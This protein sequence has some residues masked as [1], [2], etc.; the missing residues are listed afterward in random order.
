MIRQA[1]PKRSYD[2]E[3]LHRRFSAGE[4]THQVRQSLGWTMAQHWG[5][6]VLQLGTTMVL[7]RL[8]TP[9]DY[10]L[11]GMALTV[12]VIV[13]QLRSMGLSSAVVQRRDLTMNQV[14][15]LFYANALA[16]LV[17]A[18]LVA[19]LAP[20]VAAFY[21]RPELVPITLAL[22]ATYALS[23]FGV[24]ASALL[25]RRLDFRKLAVRQ[26][27]ARLLSSLIAVAAAAVGAGYWALVSQQLAF[28][29]FMLVLVWV[30]VPWR[31]GRP[32]DVRAAV[33]LVKFGAGVSL[34]GLFSAFGGMAD[35]III[36]RALG[37]ADLGLYSRAHALQKMPLG[38]L[39]Q[40]LNGAM[41]P[42][43]SAVQEEPSRYRRLYTGAI[44]GLGMVALPLAIL[45]AVTATDT[46][47]VFLGEQ[48]VDAAPVFR[49]LALAGFSLVI[50]SSV[51]WLYTSVG[52]GK[53]FAQ[54]SAVAAAVRIVACFIG[55]RWGVVGVAAALATT[56]T[57]LAPAA[58][59]FGSRGTPV[60]VRDIATSLVRP[61]V[62]SIAVLVSSLGVLS[63]VASGMAPLITLVV[64]SSAAVCTWLL[65]VGSWPSAR[66][67][68]KGLLAVMRPASR[69]AKRS[70][71]DEPR[72]RDGQK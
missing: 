28:S 48:W 70:A 54:W 42:L 60:G 72:M 49:W 43:L 3:H 6:F 29:L 68:V 64:V 69:G 62:I 12:T 26:T 27:A 9:E 47:L 55:I 50:T 16:G 65:V 18:A 4:F 46:I 56:Q 7:A 11:V 15:T 41:T 37:A 17:L 34:A 5:S 25:T 24:Q 66:S 38:Q 71:T 52:R 33:P 61:F 8:L 58:L 36:G 30:A 44:G 23:G 21:G 10:G 59:Y 13:D 53:A 2:E 31:P 35:R 67:Q 22:S 51:S 32:R 39:I 40:P 14:N 45:L 1:R 20:L 63:T 57:A 19:T